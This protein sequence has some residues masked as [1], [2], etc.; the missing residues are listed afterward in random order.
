[1]NKYLSKT[2][3]GVTGCLLIGVSIWLTKSAW[4][5]FGLLLVAFLLDG[6]D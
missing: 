4:C 1:M 3:V 5:I 2:L 6:I